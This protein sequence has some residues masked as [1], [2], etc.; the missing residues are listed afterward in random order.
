MLPRQRRV[1]KEEFGEVLKKGLS[2]HSLHLFLRGVK[3]DEVSPS[4]FSVVVSKKVASRAVDRNLLRRRATAVLER[5]LFGMKKG[6]SAIFSFKT[7]SLDLSSAQIETEITTL[8]KQSGL[9]A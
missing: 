4:K 7:G 5:H 6:I 8:L 2:F 1:H 9:V 3:K